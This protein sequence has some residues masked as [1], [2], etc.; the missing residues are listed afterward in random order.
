MLGTYFYNEIFK[1]T[2]IGFGTLFNNIQLRR[3]NGGDVEVMKVPLA[4]GPTE[5][6]LSRLRENPNLE[7]RRVQ[8]TVPRIGFQLTSIA[9]DPTR[10]VAPTQVIKVPS[11]TPGE[12][13]KG[14]M[15]VP[16]NL[17]FEVDIISKNQDDALQIL[18]QIL[19][20]FQPSLSISVNLLT[21]LNETKD[22]LINLE[23]VDFRDD[24][25]GSFADNRILIYSLRFSAKTY[26]F[27]P[28]KEAT[29]GLIKKVQ[30]DQYTDVDT[31]RAREVRYSVTPKAKQDYNADGEITSL[32]DAFVSAGDDFGFNELTSE[33]TDAARW[34][35]DS[36]ED[37]A[38]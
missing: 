10:K 4:Y 1:K 27:G 23:S 32:D 7:G 21:A 35:P 34:N 5:K 6:F 33:F 17:G 20:F 24:Y 26:V 8:I 3:A 11:A 9:Y 2:I 37:E 18:E 31:S 38:I 22:V 12:V 36:G 30:V 15:P 16:Y 29:G 14:Y 19:P 25:E 28:V 13:D